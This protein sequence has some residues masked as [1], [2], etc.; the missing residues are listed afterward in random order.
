MTAKNGFPR[1]FLGPSQL[2]VDHPI[3]TWIFFHIIS[4]PGIAD[5]HPNARVRVL[6]APSIE[7]APFRDRKAPRPRNGLD[8]VDCNRS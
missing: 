1:C 5:T 4:T 2:R 8:G 6:S 7:E 3:L